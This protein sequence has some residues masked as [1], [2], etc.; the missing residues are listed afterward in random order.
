MVDDRE[1]LDPEDKKEDSFEFDSAGEAVG[2]ISMPQARVLAMRTAREEPGNYG[3]AYEGVDMFFEAVEEEED[4]DYYVITLSFRPQ[5]DFSG[6]PGREQFFITKEGL[7][8]HRQVAAPLRS[9]TVD[10]RP[11]PKRQRGF[12]VVPAVIG[13]AIVVL[14]VIGGVV[15]GGGMLGGGGSE[16]TPVA[17]VLPVETSQSVPPTPTPVPPAQVPAPAAPPTSSPPAP[18]IPPTHTPVPPTQIPPP[19]PTAT[20]VPPTQVPPPTPT[21]TTFRE[22]AE[23]YAD[24]AQ[25]A[26][27]DIF[28]G[29]EGGNIWVTTS[30]KK[31]GSASIAFSRDNVIRK[32]LPTT[33][34]GVVSVSFWM[35]PTP[36][37][38]T[39]SG[40]HFGHTDTGK[41]AIKIR[42]NESHTW[43]LDSAFFNQQYLAPYSEAWTFIQMTLDTVNGKANVRLNG[44]QVASNASFSAPQGI[45]IIGVI[46][47][48]GGSAHTSYFDDLVLSSSPTPTA[49]P[50][51]TT[52]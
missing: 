21:P 23:G 32:K 20:P 27:W 6:T 4:E 15:I 39:N 5:G 35:F 10:D 13:L 16:E 2:Y 22:D 8:D 1:N 38:N 3:A 17:A 12:P 36:D 50:V 52:P 47:G 24:G 49:T 51:P 30:V 37:G 31:V 45:N 28:E 18:A 48:R 29:G 42:I 14:V 46:S 33:L 25:P 44:V 26:G 41:E 7:V 34:T 11:E 19:T 43:F 40:F 9:D